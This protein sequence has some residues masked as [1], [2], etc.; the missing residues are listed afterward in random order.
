MLSGVELEVNKFVDIEGR[1]RVP[2][3]QSY[4]V[5]KKDVFVPYMLPSLIASA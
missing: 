4:H 3:K 5:N 1:W 2:Y